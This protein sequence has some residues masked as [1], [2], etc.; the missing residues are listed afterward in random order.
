MNLPNPDHLSPEISSPQI[1]DFGNRVL[2]TCAER[3]SG[4]TNWV[5]AVAQLHYSTE[6]WTK[7]LSLEATWDEITGNMLYTVKIEHIQ[8]FGDDWRPEVAKSYVGMGWVQPLEDVGIGYAHDELEEQLADTGIP[9]SDIGFSGT[10]T[11]YVFDVPFGNYTARAHKATFFNFYD[12]S[13]DPMDVEFVHYVDA[14][15]NLTTARDIEHL[16]RFGEVALDVDAAEVELSQVTVFD[17]DVI[18]AGLKKFGLINSRQVTL[19]AGLR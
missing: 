13:K 10:E 12:E 8:P 5:E 19:R 1:R 4:D 9:V 18:I 11:V 16:I 6:D 7:L 2:L 3:L 17:L 15:T 14:F